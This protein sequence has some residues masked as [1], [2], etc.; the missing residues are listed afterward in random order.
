MKA[1]LEKSSRNFKGLIENKNYRKGH[2]KSIT[3]IKEME[4]D[5]EINKKLDEKFCNP[6]N[7]ISKTLKAKDMMSYLHTNNFYKESLPSKSF[8]NYIVDTKMERVTQEFRINH[9]ADYDNFNLENLKSL[10]NQKG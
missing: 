6:F 4:N 8:T 3:T 2:Y 5:K 9:I 1:S 10:F 7:H